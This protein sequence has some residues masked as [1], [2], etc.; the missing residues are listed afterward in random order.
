MVCCPQIL[1]SLVKERMV[2]SVQESIPRPSHC[3]GTTRY[4][5]LPPLLPVVICSV[6]FV[7]QNVSLVTWL[8]TGFEPSSVCAMQVGRGGAEG[9]GGIGD[10]R[11]LMLIVFVH[12]PNR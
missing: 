2:E 6:A 8:V 5:P 4:A 7:M 11:E 12:T 1:F 3:I 9:W 10:R